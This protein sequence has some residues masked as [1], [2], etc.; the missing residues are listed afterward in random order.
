M[1]L[2]RHTTTSC[3][4]YD[5]CFCGRVNPVAI[6]FSAEL[7]VIPF[8][9]S[10]VYLSFWQELYVAREFPHVHCWPV[11]HACF[12]VHSWAT[13]DCSSWFLQGALCADYCSNKSGGCRQTGYL[14][15][16]FQNK[17]EET[18]LVNFRTIVFTSRASIGLVLMLVM[19]LP[20][21]ILF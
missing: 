19:L 18:K 17:R 4:D 16:K 21:C 3:D 2:Q 5:Y 6:M 1:A 9:A 10:Q 8:L 14:H 15:A 11:V 20:E 13:G 12:P 7:T